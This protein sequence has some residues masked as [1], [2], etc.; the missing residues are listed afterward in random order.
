[1]ANRTT[2][3]QKAVSTLAK[4]VEQH[5]NDLYDAAALLD[6]AVE[7][8]DELPHGRDGD[9]RE[10]R[11]NTMRLVQMASG[12]VKAAADALFENQP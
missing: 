10:Y 7:R 9:A 4:A 1:M 8:L 5:L 12:R 2:R 6:A 3:Q 11:H